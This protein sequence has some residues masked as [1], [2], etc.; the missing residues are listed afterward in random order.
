MINI[1]GTVITID[2][3]GTQVE[4]V[5]KILPLIPSYK[6]PVETKQFDL[7]I[8][9]IMSDFI[10]GR[11]HVLVADSAFF[12]DESAFSYNIENFLV[13]RG[14]FYGGKIELLSEDFDWNFASAYK[15]LSLCA[16]Q[17]ENSQY[18]YTYN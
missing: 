6:A 9:V 17:E 1:K 3:M 4:I 2:A 13:S 5:E 8:Y 11:S 14:V 7:S 18:K 16:N 12:K 15:E 10:E